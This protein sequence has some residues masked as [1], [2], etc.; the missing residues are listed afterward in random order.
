MENNADLSKESNVSQLENVDFSDFGGRSPKQWKF[1]EK[2]VSF[3][4]VRM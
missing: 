3:C 4:L 1:V 2:I